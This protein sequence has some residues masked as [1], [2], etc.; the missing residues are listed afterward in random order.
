MCDH[1]SQATTT[2]KR[3]PIQNTKILPVKALQLE[4]LVNDHLPPHVSDR[5]YFLTWRLMIFHCFFKPSLDAF[6]D[7]YVRCVYLMAN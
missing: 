5:D 3:P 7:L 6:S 2:H 1:L 4:R